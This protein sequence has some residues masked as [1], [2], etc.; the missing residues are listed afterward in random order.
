MGTS[1]R[2]HGLVALIA[3][4]ALLVGAPA[5]PAATPR[6]APAVGLSAVVEQAVL[7]PGQTSRILVERTADGGRTWTPVSGAVVRAPRQQVARVGRD[8][9]VRALAPGR[10]VVDVRHARS[11]TT[12][13]VDVRARARTRALVSE[14]VRTGSSC[15]C[16]G[17]VLSGRGFR[18]SAPIT[19]TTDGTPG[20]VVDASASTDASGSFA[21]VVG[22]D[23]YVVSGPSWTADRGGSGLPED[24]CAPG[25]S[26]TITATDPDGASAS[27]RGSC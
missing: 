2:R 1:A 10:V 4:G 15:D 8:G 17:G 11:R 20:L 27:F 6:A 3:L 22:E 24:G 13:L 9:T 25:T 14:A 5:A 19:L 7:A 26:W 16:V 12:V 23:G 21:G 18:P